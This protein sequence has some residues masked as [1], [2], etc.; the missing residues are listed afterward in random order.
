MKCSVCNKELYD[1]NSVVHYNCIFFTCENC[2]VGDPP[3]TPLFGFHIGIESREIFQFYF[4]QYINDNYYKL[5]S[6]Q[7]YTEL[8]CN[9]KL[10]L[11]N[12]NFIKVS[13]ENIVEISKNFI[14]KVLKLKAFT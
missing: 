10:I 12:D 11:Q 5:V 7:H 6:K 4:N 14:E 13:N 3:S 9:N 1:E 2:K 8:I